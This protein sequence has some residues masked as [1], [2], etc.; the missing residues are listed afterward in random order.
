MS[1][2]INSHCGLVVTHTLHDAYSMIKD[3]LHRGREAYGIAAIGERSIDVLKWVAPFGR[4][5]LDGLH[6]IFPGE[7]YHTYLFHVRYATSGRKDLD[8]LLQDAHPHTIGGTVHKEANHIFVLGC[9]IAGVHNGQVNPEF[10]TGID[11]SKLKTG[12]D[13]EALLH[14]Y[15]DHGEYGLVKNIPGAY[16]LAIADRRKQGVIVIRDR[17]GIRPGTLGW[18]DGKYI[19][20]SED[21]ALRKNGGTLIQDLNPGSVYRL[22][23][24]GSYEEEKV[25]PEQLSLCFFEGNYQADRDS[26]L[27]GASVQRIRSLQGRILA[28]EFSSLDLDFVTFVPRCSKTAA[29]AFAAERGLPLERIFL[30]ANAERSFQGSTEEERGRSITENLYL[31]PRAELKLG[32]K[33]VGVLEDSTVRGNAVQRVRHLLYDVGRVKVAH[34]INCTPPI[35]IIGDDGEERGCSYGID[36]PPS[37]KFIAR[38]K[39]REEISTVAGMPIYYISLEGMLSAFR[40]SGINPKDLCTFCIGGKKPF[41]LEDQLVQI[42]K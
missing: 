32:G 13:T 11:T 21:I 10:L 16:T 8:K 31:H 1:E 30:K 38:G 23:E 6:E 3:L 5:D 29:I 12:C 40:D 25:V 39:T 26:I 4:F 24:N 42:G 7:D 19:V 14:Y 37:S 20:T 2:E 34:L 33:R 15:R 22:L 18:K 36:M 35:G 9:E 27:N 28:R 17:T 41:A